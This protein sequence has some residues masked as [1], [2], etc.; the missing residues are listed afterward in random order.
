MT[1]SASPGCG[2]RAAAA[3][4]ARPGARTS[5]RAR[6]IWEKTLQSVTA[7]TREDGEALLREAAVIPIRPHVQRYALADAN[8]ALADVAGDRVQGTAVLMVD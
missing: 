3:D 7:N 6:P 2:P 5:A 4:S 8:R 1:A